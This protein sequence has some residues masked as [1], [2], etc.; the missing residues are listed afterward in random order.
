MNMKTAL[1]GALDSGPT[2]SDL[3]LDDVRP[4]PQQPRKTFDEEALKDLAASIEQHGLVQPIVVRRD[5]ENSGQYLITA[6]ERRFRAVRLL[7]QPT[8]SAIIR[9]EANAAVV[10][11]VENLQ[12]VDLSPIEE[13]E[14][15]ARLIDEQGL[16]QNQ[17]AKL[18]GKNRLTINQLLK[19]N[20]LPPSIR[21]GAV[22]TDVSKSILIELAQLKDEALQAKLWKKAQSGNLTVSEIRK[23]RKNEE[24]SKTTDGPT[25]SGE[26]VRRLTPTQ[27][28]LDRIKK[29]VSALEAQPMTEDERAE[30]RE[31]INQLNA[32]T[33]TAN[34]ASEG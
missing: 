5:P 7:K 1:F 4:D 2:I 3:P 28:A 20:S 10:A 19:V 15:I 21:A 14:A 16:N 31:L 11:I 30:V 32:L 17:A 6:G 34:S 12:R 9:D 29:G 8:I 26:D 22:E 23:A 27:S 24:G 25:K 33:V 18:I 13:A